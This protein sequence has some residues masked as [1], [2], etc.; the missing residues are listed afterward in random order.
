MN[1][2]ALTHTDKN[3]PPIL[4]INSS[5]PRFHAGRDDMIAILNQNNIYNEVHTIKDAPH[6][7]W[8]FNPWFDETIR[9]T[10]QFLDKIFK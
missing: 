7:F 4:F 10:T 1:A 3:T 8:F 2:S 5:I 9:Y 6:S